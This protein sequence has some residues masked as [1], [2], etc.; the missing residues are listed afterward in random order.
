MNEVFKTSMAVDNNNIIF[1]KNEYADEILK[2]RIQ[3]KLIGK[4]IAGEL[5]F[6]F[7]FPDNSYLYFYGEIKMYKGYIFTLVESCKNFDYGLTKGVYCFNT[8][9]Q[10]IWHVEANILLRKIEI[11]DKGNIYFIEM[12]DKRNSILNCFSISGVELYKKNI[13]SYISDFILDDNNNIIFINDN[14]EICIEVRI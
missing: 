14:Y 7:E 4:T 5:N 12:V 8:S 6:E 1:Y 3:G 10:Y 9:G 11:D 2:E 13:K